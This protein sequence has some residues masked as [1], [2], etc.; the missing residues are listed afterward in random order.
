MRGNDPQQ[1]ALFSYLSPAERV[2]LDHPLRAIRVMMDAVLK[3]LSP[4]FAPLSS[5]TGR[6]SIAPEKLLRAA[7]ASALHRA[8]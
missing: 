8:Q 6:P 2:A 1:A 7:A 4:Q 5:H 3:E